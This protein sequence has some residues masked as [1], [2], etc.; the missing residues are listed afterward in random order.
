MCLEKGHL[1]NNFKSRKP[2]VYCKKSGNHHQFGS[3]EQLFRSTEVI[4]AVGKQVIIQTAMVNH[5]C[6]MNHDKKCE[7]KTRLLLDCG[8]QQSY[9][10]R[11]GE[12]DESEANK[13]EFTD[14]LHLWNCQ[15]KE[16]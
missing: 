7:T 14:C 1:L 4:A 15:T 10:I 9:Y 13:Q 12:E 8:A 2:S 16:Y 3:T 6:P 5:V 11:I